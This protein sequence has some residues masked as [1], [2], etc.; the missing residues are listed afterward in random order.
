MDRK[1]QIEQ[2]WLHGPADNLQSFK[3]GA[4]WADEHPIDMWRKP[5]EEKPGINQM[6]LVILRSGNMSV[7]RYNLD[8]KFERTFECSMPM[9]DGGRVN[10]GYK[11]TFIESV[12][13]W[14]PLPKTP[15]DLLTP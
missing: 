12:Q 3:K 7:V 8:G 6:V 13:Y 9:M 11:Q 5:E 4:E 15:N 10:F 1:Q 2:A 14:M